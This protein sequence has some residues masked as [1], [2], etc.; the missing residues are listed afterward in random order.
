VVGLYLNPPEGAVVHCVDEK[1][2]VEALARSQP[3]FPMMPG[4]PEKRFGLSLARGRPF[5]DAGWWPG[6]PTDLDRG[7]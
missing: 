2:Q 4:M 3:A 1:R 6:V 7:R 5:R